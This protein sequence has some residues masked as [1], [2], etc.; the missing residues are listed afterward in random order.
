LVCT[1]NLSAGGS[2]RPVEQ[3]QPRVDG[4]AERLIELGNAE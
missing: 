4:F 2:A 3:N 1:A